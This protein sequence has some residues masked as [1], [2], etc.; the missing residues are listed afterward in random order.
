M[1]GRLRRSPAW[2]VIAV[3]ILVLGPAS[4]GQTVRNLTS[5]P[6][7]FFRS[8]SQNALDDVGSVAYVVSSSNPFGTN[9]TH[10]PQIMQWDPVTGVGS[11]VTSFAQGVESVSVGD[12]GSWL[13]F[14]SCSNPA[15]SNHDGSTE[16]F[17]MEPDGTDL[18]PL[19][20]DPAVD[21]GTVSSALLS[22]SGSR[23]VFV[24]NTDPLGTNP[25]R[26]DQVFVVNRDGTGLRQLT[27]ATVELPFYLSIEISISD[28][29]ERVV[30]T[31]SR[32]LTGGN[33]GGWLQAFGIQADG[34]GL[35]Q[36]TNATNGH[37]YRPMLSGNGA[38]FVFSSRATFGGP[39]GSWILKIE[40][41]GTGFLPLAGPNAYESSITDDGLTVV[42][43]SVT[44]S[45]PGSQIWKVGADGTGSA[46]LTSG[47]VPSNLRPVVSGDGGRIVFTF[48]GGQYAGGNNPD[49]GYELASMDASGGGL[50]Q[51]T[52]LSSDFQP[53]VYGPTIT[54]DGTRLFFFSTSN[55]LGSN[56]G[57]FNQIFRIQTDGSGLAQVTNLDRTAY[58]MSASQDGNLVV[59]SDYWDIF[60]IN[61]DGTGLVRLTPAAIGQSSQWP[62]LRYDGQFL[63]FQSTL[64]VGSNTDY[65]P[66]LFRVRINGLNLAPITADDDDNYK[67][68]RM[69][70][71]SNPTWIVF[72][73]ASNQDGLNSD[74]SL[75][76]FRVKFDG[77]GHER[78]TADPAHWSQEP[79]ISS[80]ANRIVYTSYADPLGTN[81]EHNPE[82]FLYDVPTGTRRQLTFTT[83]GESLTPRIT[84][85]GA[86]IYFTSSAPF[87]ETNPN[88]RYEPYR[89][90]VASGVVE[91]VG[92]T[93]GCGSSID[94]GSSR[95]P[96]GVSPDGT[97]TRA[98]FAG[99]GDWESENP[100]L[101]DEV[102]LVDHSARATIEVGKSAPTLLSWAPE[103]KPRRYDIIRG[104][105]ANL[106]LG[107]GS[108]V[109]LGPVVCLE[110]DSPDSDTRG[111]EDAVQ[112][113]QGHVFFYLY[114]GTQGLS[115]GPGSWGQGSAGKERI[116][117]AGSC[118]P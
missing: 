80:D 44:S 26:F 16:L 15:G 107:G 71:T 111:N 103:P 48:S 21:A 30:F 41:D 54:P 117:G 91:R 61:A 74:G 19:T 59:F 22:G 110:D 82:I 3:F 96:N 97:G 63:V 79:D 65:S 20:N 43:S 32:D 104:D 49:G 1:K 73:S 116:A 106:S 51:L 62:V 24:A 38:R 99:M 36:L 84:R 102:Y 37:V 57:H 10:S 105:V 67:M 76:V 113:S 52:F 34:T 77:T 56:P 118:S 114:R 66:E 28:D 9:P 86:W 90:S 53:Y 100:D 69:S 98:V 70:E 23:A 29:G 78:L 101:S 33:P 4:E 83:S 85:D 25:G 31:D 8:P 11:Q 18:A 68:P 47:A 14:V 58:Q 88:D 92:G 6:A 39:G 89:V 95:Y 87:F 40:W 5:L 27:N 45:S 60:R 64:N 109:Q 2:A 72:Q 46:Q 7:E 112:P 42:L 93:L 75:E 13:A 12:D 115:D 94:A 81:P 55:V 50:Q 35:R 17:V 108:T